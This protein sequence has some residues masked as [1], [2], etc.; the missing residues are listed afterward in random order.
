MTALAGSREA[1]RAERRPGG[2][3]G[4]PE[5]LLAGDRDVELLECTL[6][7][8]SYAV[9]F[10]FTGRDTG[11]IVGLLARVGVRYVEVGHGLGLGASEAGKGAMPASD[12]AIIA[13]AKAAAGP[14]R[15][16][17]FCIPGLA[18]LDMLDRAAAA[19]LDFVRVGQE[20]AAPE[21]AYPFL[22]RARRLGLLTFMNFMKSY[23]ITAE[24]FGRKARDAVRAGAQA[25]CL[26]DS[27]GGM[28]PADV[29]AYLGEAAR[30]DC[31]LGFHGHDNLRLAVANCLEARRCGARFID[32]TLYGLGRNAGNAPTEVLAALF[33]LTG[34]RTGVDLFA[35]L[36]EAERCMEPLIS[37]FHLHD[38]TAVAMGYGRFHS[39]FLPAAAQ[40]A[41]RHGADL[42]RLA[43]RLGRHDPVRLDPAVLEET[44]R[45]LAGTARP[46]APADGLVDFAAPGFAAGRLNLAPGS[47][48]ALV[49]GLATL[50]AKRG[51]AV[52]ALELTPAPEELPGF[53]APSFVLATGR[54]VLGRL[55]YGSLE[56]LEA[57]LPALAGRVGLFLVDA[58]GPDWGEGA[59][60]RLLRAAGLGPAVPIHARRVRARFVAARAAVEAGGGEDSSLLVHG[61]DE[62]V[63]DELLAL[64]VFRRLVVL[65]APEGFRRPGVICLRD[66]PDRLGLDLGL[67]AA[68]LLARPT[69]RGLASL[70]RALRPGAAILAVTGGGDHGGVP[71]GDG[72]VLIRPESAYAGVLEDALACR[73]GAES[74]P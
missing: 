25:V 74:R 15:V 31:A 27:V 3:A 48:E 61:H 60:R 2:V 40:A 58:G 35:L 32:S 71:A 1:A 34:A 53:L 18:T 8:G 55:V 57:R 62:A 67:D 47:V 12:E 17:A 63:L 49:D 24:E 36:D 23:A 72:L 7:D 33:E 45:Q 50:A 22:E 65:G 6:R 52:A 20:A 46:P 41:G 14:A 54:A 26:V 43:A 59:A 39:S 66:E 69:E 37:H 44:A 4:E 10:R 29:A 13:E 5:S 21:T 68:L 73:A 9:D 42:K 70:R 30:A 51:G 28:L 56:T 11:L 19:G 64:R 16:G 38:M